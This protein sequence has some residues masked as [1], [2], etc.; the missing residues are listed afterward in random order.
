M[1]CEQS[2]S[3]FTLIEL[4]VVIAVIAILAA[5]LLPALSRAKQKTWTTVCQNNQKQLLLKFLMRRED[6]STRLDTQP[7]G[8]WYF[9]DFAS[10]SKQK[11]VSVCPA[12][13]VNP[14]LGQ[15]STS[16]QYGT[17]ASA[18]L[19][20]GWGSPVSR[21]TYTGSYGGNYWLLVAGV[22]A[23][24]PDGIWG[25]GWSITGTG[26]FLPGTFL[27]E[28]Q[29]AHPAATP[30]LAD[31][32]FFW[33]SPYPTDPPAKDLANGYDPN[34]PPG[35]DG[36]GMC[37]FTIPRHGSRPTPVPTNWPANRRLPG[38]INVSLFDGHVELVKLDRLW[39]FYWSADWVPP[40]TRPGL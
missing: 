3:A 15:L 33:V 29:V 22:Y 26:G 1:S 4:L 10:P 5:L 35:W 17:V 30:L 31:S 11:S 27:S 20:S 21:E 36:P 16:W 40:A 12:A 25:H 39:Q 14:A 28:Q 38:A 6:G 32:V 8:E 7:M 9:E 19:T 24:H 18:W 34:F 23:A 13:P 37:N 2:R